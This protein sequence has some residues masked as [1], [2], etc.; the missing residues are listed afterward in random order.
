M[1][2]IG[3]EKF[4]LNMKYNY[5]KKNTSN[6]DSILREIKEVIISIK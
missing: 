1:S 6:L 4:F 5:F 3:G 2:K